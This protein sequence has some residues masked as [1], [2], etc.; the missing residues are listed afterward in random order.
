MVYVSSCEIIIVIVII[1][2]SFATFPLISGRA[3]AFEVFH[4]LFTPAVSTG[5]FAT[6]CSKKRRKD[7]ATIAAAAVRSK[8]STANTIYRTA[9]AFPR[10]HTGA[11]M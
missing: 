5:I 2:T 11:V 6:I 7:N 8:I 9:A 3:V 4:S 10:S 1:L